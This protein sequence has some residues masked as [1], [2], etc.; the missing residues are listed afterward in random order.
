[1]TL[2]I[3]NGRPTIVTHAP[4]DARDLKRALFGASVLGLVGSVLAGPLLGVTVVAGVFA[5][6]SF[7]IRVEEPSEAIEPTGTGEPTAIDEPTG[8][9]ERSPI[10]DR[11]SDPG[12]R[13]S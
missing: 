13:D 4:D 8:A 2:R 3:E 6:I 9:D 10:E 1:M 11:R 12:G 7:L 5:A